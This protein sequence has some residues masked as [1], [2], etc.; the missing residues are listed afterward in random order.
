ML[1]LSHGTPAHR[2]R[3]VTKLH[4]RG[5]LLELD[6]DKAVEW[7]QDTERWKAFL[8]QLH[9]LA[10]IKPRLYNIVIQFIPLTFRPE[11]DAEL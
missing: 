5:I 8:V 7:L 2:V 11:K 9:K 3:A 1:L 6:S 10:V 4:N